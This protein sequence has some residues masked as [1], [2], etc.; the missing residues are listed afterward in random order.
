MLPPIA[1]LL[2]NRKTTAS[3]AANLAD[4]LHGPIR[5]MLQILDGGTTPFATDISHTMVT[6]RFAAA[7]VEKKGRSVAARREETDQLGVTLNNEQ[8]SLRISFSCSSDSTPVLIFTVKLLASLVIVP[9]WLFPEKI[10]SI[11][12][13]CTP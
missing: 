3:Q 2:G 5:P 1:G 12:R 4:K 10:F 11:L 8:I 7:S 6:P 9:A 13:S